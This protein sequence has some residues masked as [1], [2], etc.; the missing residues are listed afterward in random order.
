MR[1][2]FW[3]IFEKKVPIPN[4]MKIRPEGAELFRADGLHEEANSR[5]SQICESA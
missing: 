5:F 4:F 3:Q 2:E 1:L